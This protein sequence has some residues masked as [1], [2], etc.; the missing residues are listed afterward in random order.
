M[1]RFVY[2]GEFDKEYAYDGGEG[3]EEKILRAVTGWC[4]DTPGPACFQPRSCAQ[5]INYVSA[6][7][8]FTLWDK[9]VMS[10]HGQEADFS[11]VYEDVLRANKLAALIY[12]TCQGSLFLSGGRRVRAH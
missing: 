10:L 1:K 11:I 4:A 9:L 7:D 12:F 2:S 8:N 5:I 3:L 6:H